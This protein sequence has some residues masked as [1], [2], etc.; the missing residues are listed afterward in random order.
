MEQEALK[1]Q[2]SR[3][4]FKLQT[5]KAGAVRLYRARGSP[6]SA[7]SKAWLDTFSPPICSR[8]SAPMITMPALESKLVAIRGRWVRLALLC[9]EPD[10]NL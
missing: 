1:K 7:T 2:S 8:G 4:V 9:Q 3:V 10:L 6:L 5:Y